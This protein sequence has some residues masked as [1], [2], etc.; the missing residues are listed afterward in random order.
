MEFDD[1]LEDFRILRLEEVLR[2]SGLSRSQFMRLRK[3]GLT[4]MTRR[5]GPRSVGYYRRDV[6]E[7]LK[8]LPPASP[9]DPQ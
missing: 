6:R 5:L 9:D 2:L 3:A 7:W 1:D 8:S 4:P